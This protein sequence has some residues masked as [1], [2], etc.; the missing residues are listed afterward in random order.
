[1]VPGEKTRKNDIDIF[2]TAWQAIPFNVV[3]KTLDIQSTLK[4]PISHGKSLHKVKG[5]L[6][7]RQFPTNSSKNKFMR[8][9]AWQTLRGNGALYLIVS[10][11]DSD[12]VYWLH[13]IIHY[14]CHCHQW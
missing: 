6:C 13:L 8:P 14:D 3:N 12:N 1:M 2:A 5:C 10:N 7:A 9:N 11:D 4:G